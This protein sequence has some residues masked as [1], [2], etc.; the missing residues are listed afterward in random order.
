MT[1]V[2]ISY[3]YENKNQRD[4]VER[5]ARDG[6]LG[7]VR[8][9]GETEDVRQDGQSAIRH[10]INEK[11]QQADVVVALAG[12]DSHNSAWVN[13]EINYALSAGKP[14]IGARIHETTGGPPRFIQNCVLIP[15][16]PDKLRAAL[17]I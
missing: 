4:A 13:H 8:I 12:Q 17:G 5:W 14:V 2:L 10:H 11:L 9:I 6:K 15:L 1:T 7:D 3:K 16:N